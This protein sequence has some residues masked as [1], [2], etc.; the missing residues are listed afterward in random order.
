MAAL[1]AE[2]SQV[3]PSEAW[4]PWVPNE[5]QPWD[6]KWIAHLYRRAAFGA[7]PQ[8]LR[9]AQ[10]NGFAKTLSRLLTGEP[11]AADKLGLLT[12]TGSYYNEPGNLRVWWLYTMIESGHP[13]REKL[14]LFWHNHFATSYAKVR[15]TRLMFE[16]NLILRKYAL[17]QFRPFLLDMSKDTAMLV[18]LDSNRNLKGA[19]NENYSREVMELFSLGVGN[20]TEK[21]VQEAARAFTGW[22]HDSEIRTF[23]NNPTLHDDGEK[24]VLKQ[25]GKWNGSDIVRICC[26]QKAC[27]KFLVG[28]LYDFLISETSPPEPLLEPLEERFRSSGYD[29]GALVAIMLESRI[30]FSEHAYRK[31]VKWPVEYAIGA[32]RS[33]T[34]GRIPMADL[35]DPLSKMGQVLFAPP[36][37]KGWR[38]GTDWLNSATLLARN[39]FAETV[40]LGAWSRQNNRPEDR[41]NR[42]AV[43]SDA[44]PTTAKAGPGE[45]PTPTPSSP[46]DVITILYTPQPRD[47]PS[48][49]QR[50]GELVYGQP[51]ARAQAAKI[52]HFLNQ[53]GSVSSPKPK[54][55]PSAPNAGSDILTASIGPPPGQPLPKVVVATP[56]EVAPRPHD[57][58]PKP[59]YKPNLASTEFHARVREALHAMMCL[60]EY[61][62]N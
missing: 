5:A 31:K 18:W 21:D 8:E 29:I 60:P 26:E 38:T 11:D 55:M 20:Y 24:T 3:D 25:T 49:V 43:V 46:A 41:T 45:P 33:V 52:E 35:T 15:S 10:T 56:R 32:V 59:P 12:E 28:K 57:A 58:K 27:A 30:F 40:S 17:G 39:N 4:S 48:L 19:P 34:P 61:Q 37:V 16:Q 14:T 53:P 42:V 9:Q 54:V 6:R 44:K 13:L 1:P 36:N 62:L 47:I 23:E 22:H 7:T 50:M 2:L 51:I